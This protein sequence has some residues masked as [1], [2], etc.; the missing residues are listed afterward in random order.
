MGFKMLFKNKFPRLN[1]IE[2][3]SITL[4]YKYTSVLGVC[5]CVC[6]FV[7]VCVCVKERNSTICKAFEKSLSQAA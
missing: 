4:K 1:Q 2:V 7:C 6:V 5:V 3:K